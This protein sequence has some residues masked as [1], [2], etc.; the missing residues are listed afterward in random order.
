MGEWPRV[1]SVDGGSDM[2]DAL[3]GGWTCVI[4]TVGTIVSG[5]GGYSKWQYATESKDWS[6][7]DWVLESRHLIMQLYCSSQI[8]VNTH[9]P[10]NLYNHKGPTIPL[11]FQ[12]DAIVYFVQIFPPIVN[13][14]VNKWDEYIVSWKFTI[15]LQ[16]KNTQVIIYF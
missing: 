8:S 6:V 7:T 11:T 3:V 14:S 12:N 15:L 9:I 13:Y 16:H 1:A 10:D 4:T 5:G 2:G